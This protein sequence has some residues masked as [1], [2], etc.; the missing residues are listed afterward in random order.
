M[1]SAR[2]S[3]ARRLAFFEVDELGLDVMDQKI[4]RT[5]IEKFSGAPVGLNTLATA[6]VRNPNTLE[7]VYEPIC[8]SSA[9]SGGHRAGRVATERAYEHLGFATPGSDSRLF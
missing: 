5:L 8:C 2:R 4:L 9:S 6:L 7:D 1:S 3:R